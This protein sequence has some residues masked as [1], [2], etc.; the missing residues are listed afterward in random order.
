MGRTDELSSSC[1]GAD[2]AI[3]RLACTLTETVLPVK[4][5]FGTEAGHFAKRGVPAI[6]CGPGHMNVAHKPDE[7]VQLGQLEACSTFLEGIIDHV[8]VY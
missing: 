2:N 1:G 7:Y 8:S 3:E 5:A 6:V 4:L